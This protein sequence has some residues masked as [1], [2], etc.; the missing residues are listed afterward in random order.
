[1][2]IQAHCKIHAPKANVFAAFSD[3]SSLA[4]HV[5]AITR[6]E[7]LTPGEVGVGTE[8]KETR[9]MFGKEATETM[10]IT[11]FSPPDRLVEEAHSSGMHYVSEW[12]F[13]ETGGETTVTINFSG[14]RGP[15]ARAATRDV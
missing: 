9:V 12:T 6:V 7:I 14:Q 2:R 11:E 1:M 5:K 4:T 8:F 13:S 15:P 10:R 3:L